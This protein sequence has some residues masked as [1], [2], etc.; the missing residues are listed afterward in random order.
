MQAKIQFSLLVVS[1]A[2]TNTI[3]FS[4][5]PGCG[6]F[7]ALPLALGWHLV[8]LL[9]GGFFADR[10]VH[11]VAAVSAVLSACVLAALMSILVLIANRMGWLAQPQGLSKL[12]VGG[13]VIYV[14]LG[15]LP[16]PVGPCF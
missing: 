6:T 1:V 3:V 2:V 9:R 7:R 8:D 14:I 16:I 12:L 11:L 4:A 15:L 13:A 5:V 10:H